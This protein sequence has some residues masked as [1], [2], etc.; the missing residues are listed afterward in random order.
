MTPIAFYTIDSI[1]TSGQ[2]YLGDPTTANSR[3]LA[4]GDRLTPA[5]LQRLYYTAP[6]GYDGKSFFTYSATDQLGEADE[7][8][9]KVA[10][11][12]PGTNVPPDTFDGRDGRYDVA[13]GGSVKLS[14]LFG[15]DPDG[16]VVDYRI[17]KIPTSGTLFLDGRALVV[18]NEIPASRIG[19]LVFVAPAGFTGTTF[20]FAAI[21]DRDVIDPT[22]AV[23]TIG[24]IDIGEPPDTTN[25]TVKDPIAPGSVVNLGSSLGGSDSDG[26][27]A[28]YR[29]DTLPDPR[30]GRLI[31]DDPNLGISD[32]AA[33]DILTPFQLA[34][35][36]FIA[37]ATF[38]GTVTFT[39]SAI[40]NDGN[41]DPTPATVSITSTT[42]IITPPTPGTPGN[43]GDPT[44]PE[45]E[46]PTDDR[47][48]P[49]DTPR[50]ALSE[51]N[52]EL[53]PELAMLLEKD[54]LGCEPPPQPEDLPAPAAAIAP[55]LP[56]PPLVYPAWASIDLE[57]RAGDGDANRLDGS[58]ADD[59]LI[60]GLGSD[61][62]VGAERDRDAI[63]ANGGSDY[64]NGSEGND[65]IRAGK[66][67]D[68]VF[69]GKDDDELYG[70][71]GSD[72]IDGERGNDTIVGG[73][74]RF[75]DEEPGGDLDPFDAETNPNPIRS[76]DRLH[77]GEGNDV[78]SGNRDRDTITGGDGDDT[79]YGGRDHDW[80]AGEAGADVLFGDLGDDTV[81]G[82]N[83][84][85]IDR[86]D[87]DRSR[88]S[89]G[90][91]R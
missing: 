56:L 8:P 88:H 81:I 79:A 84:E 46:E 35:L 10:F 39:Y 6:T 22:P 23:I 34:N 5:E 20:E 1:P 11:P 78:I 3:L 14:D 66:G 64:L 19:D 21:D 86:F 27:V 80:V 31:I 87:S 90:W 44:D 32:V 74:A 82:G 40:D 61:A 72:T 65:T 36:K 89:P 67:D 38:N 58:A 85:A 52:C 47:F 69:G 13:P 53:P 17:T 29:I 37:A 68:Q 18:G 16:Q 76:A 26:T 28:L 60:G 15:E 55:T 50:S 75:G 70:E 7:T 42:P 77:G 43:P 51:G 41:I 54:C 57:R 9:A 4:V 59:F 25:Y 83:G 2:L 33:G 12:I 71:Y 45:P 49:L 62:P 24:A 73:T 63:Y 48:E 91:P 30:Q